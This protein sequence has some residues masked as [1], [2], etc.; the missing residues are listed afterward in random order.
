MNHSTPTGVK[1]FRARPSATLRDHVTMALVGL[2]WQGPRACAA[3]P[4]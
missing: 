4:R 3:W 1:P 2:A